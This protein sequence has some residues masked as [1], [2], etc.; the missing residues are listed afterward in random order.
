MNNEDQIQYEE[1]GGV[2]DINSGASVSQL[3]PSIIDIDSS[4]GERVELTPF[5]KIKFAADKFGM[6]LNNPDRSCK[7]CFGRGYLSVDSK[8]G[9]P[10]ACQC[11]VPKKIRQHTSND[12]IPTNRK[13]R[14]IMARLQKKGL[15]NINH[16]ASNV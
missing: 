5:E 15:I 3:K 2:I 11:V 8:T 1:F 7:K 6:E 10:V 13:S 12:F 14:R 16:D 4:T 9:I